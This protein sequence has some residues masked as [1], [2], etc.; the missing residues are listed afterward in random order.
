VPVAGYIPEL[1]AL[2]L[3]LN[4]FIKMR[5][6]V[7]LGIIAVTLS[8]KYLFNISFNTLP[9][10]IICLFLLAYNLL[11][12]LWN[13]RLA[14]DDTE[15]VIKRAQTSG[16]IQVLFDL[17]ILTILL[18][19]TGGI[20][21]PFVFVYVIHTTAASILLTKRRAYELTTIA[22][23][24][25]ALLAFL[26]YSS[27][28]GHVNLIS[29]VPS[30]IYRQLNYVISIIV[31]LALLTYTS[32][33]ITTA[34]AGELRQQHLKM[35]L[36]RDKLLK[37]DE[38]E[39]QR[40]SSEV[41]RLKDERSSFVRLLNVVTHDLQAPLVAVQSCISYVLDGYAGDIAEE[42]KNWL[43]R[44]SRRIDSLL[45]LI[46]DLLDI[47]RIELGQLKQEMTEL[48]L[49]EIIIHSTEG[50]D[51]IAKKKGL[52]FMVDIP[53]K[54]PVVNGSSRRLQQVIT[55]LINNAINYTKEGGITVKL[56]E[57]ESEVRIDII[58]TGIGVP[59]KDLPKLFDEFYRGSNVESKGSGLGLSIAKRIIAA[60]GGK[61]WAESPN[62]DT[63]QGSK[64]TFIMP[65]K[66]D[67]SQINII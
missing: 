49:N 1:K 42:Q 15:L 30:T 26:E 65:K 38:L 57:T 58:D 64:F 28:I 5:W 48:P 16:Y 33:Y 46:T 51:I 43:Q 61:I 47:P 4:V 23:G 11:M 18:H 56:T 19:F 66:I 53:R 3:R 59:A 36:L 8:A 32:T 13:R 52:Q 44:G 63:G 54:S 39:L 24:M 6:L 21:N 60:H 45:I 14:K 41:N 37:E 62:P 10:F 67:N 2:K 55:N 20:T 29:F 17:G 50:L 27:V 25:A 22:V 31:T 9:V 7:V 34:V 35:D 40:I 12:Y